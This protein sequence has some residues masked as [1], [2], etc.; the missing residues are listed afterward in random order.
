MQHLLGVTASEE[1]V[2]DGSLLIGAE[3]I[4]PRSF[5]VQ[6]L[7][8]LD[9]AVPRHLEAA[10]RGEKFSHLHPSHLLM[11]PNSTKNHGNYISVR[12]K[13]R[14]GC[15]PASAAPYL[16]VD[17]G[18]DGLIGKR[19]VRV[20]RCQHALHQRSLAFLVI[21]HLHSTVW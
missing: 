18:A 3:R 16:V 13:Q 11:T 8:D 2:R 10:S 1:E 9:N 6:T 12:S 20:S 19:H 7:L 5:A 15:C 21:V 14:D 4:Q 17:L